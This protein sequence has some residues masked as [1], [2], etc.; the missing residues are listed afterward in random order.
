MA[1]NL[2]ANEQNEPQ[3]GGRLKKKKKKIVNNKK[4]L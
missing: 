4:L 1:Q 2:F 3:I